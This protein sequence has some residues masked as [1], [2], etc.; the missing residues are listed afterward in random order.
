MYTIGSKY[1]RSRCRR[2]RLKRGT[3]IDRTPEMDK[4]LKAFRDGCQDQCQTMIQRLGWENA[5]KT[6]QPPFLTAEFYG[7]PSK[8]VIIKMI[9]LGISQMR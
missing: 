8:A 1:S 6:A 3:F 2:V 4:V 5:E 9:I 7:D